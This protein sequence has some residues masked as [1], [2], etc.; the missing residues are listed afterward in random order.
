MTDST[1][2]FITRT[3]LAELSRQRDSLLAQYHE[4]QSRA[5]GDHG[6]VGLRVLYEGLKKIA[7]GH[8]RLH[9]ELPNIHALLRGTEV[10]HELVAFWRDRFN[11][12]LARGKARA[13]IVYL[14]GAF[15]GEWD[16]R[17]EVNQVWQNDRRQQY[18][19]LLQQVTASA[20]APPAPMNL[21]D[22][23]LNRLTEHHAEIAAKIEEAIQESVRSQ[24]DCYPRLTQI[25]DSPNHPADVRAE[26]K[27]FSGDDVLSD[28]FTDAL[29][30]VTRDPRDWSWPSS[31][32]AARALWTR[33]KWRLYPVLSL[34]DLAVLNA[35]SDFWT[36]TIASCYTNAGQRV[37]R[38]GRLQHLN[39]LGA[40][41]VITFNE[42]RMLKLEQE[43][44]C[45]SWY[46][47]TDPWTSQPV[48]REGEPVRGI[49]VSRATQQGELRDAAQMGYGYGEGTNAM[50]LQVHAEIQTLRAAFPN[51]PLHVVKLDIR[52]YFASVPHATLLRMLRGL[53]MTVDGMNFAECFLAI[54]YLIDEEASPARRGVPMEQPFSHWLCEWLLRLMEEFVYARARVRII[55]QIDDICLLAPSPDEAVAGW[56]AVREFVADCGLSI[57]E[58][59]CGA[60]TIGG[61]SVDE[62]PEQPPRWSMLELNSDGDW[63]IHERTFETLLLDAR[64]EVDARHAILARVRSYNEHLRF[65]VTALGLAMDLGD[66]HRQS[67]A[68]SLSQFENT[69]FGDNK[70]VFDG[71]RDSIRERYEDQFDAIPTSWMVWPITA[72]GLGLR[73][74]LIL[75]GQFQIAYENRCDVRKS[76]PAKRPDDWQHGDREWTEYYQDLLVKLEPAE[77]GESK[78]MKT[79]VKSFIRR[80]KT[81]SGGEQ[82]GLTQYWRW[83]LSIYGPEILEH[84]GTFEFLL[85][86]LVPLQ[87][88][89]E[90]LMQEDGAES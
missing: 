10:S 15:L 42:R 71:L 72:G 11:R 49:V 45:L 76:P 48:V 13:D 4:I 55:R 52:D 50:V 83:V 41:E 30:V 68:V 69:F 56:N 21:L 62:L 27:R 18:E 63:Q 66:V 90:K 59:K 47:E 65:L 64:R 67:A 33:N 2:Q 9:R 34:V 70:S 86:E 54:P 79:L 73:S 3:K 14:F 75:D 23:Q 37:N 28:Q 82:E 40:P 16:D 51:R 8:T 85:T 22:G 61:E 20:V 87:L 1:I 78:T 60:I 81:I 12:E 26:A 31:G 32:V 44:I 24:S 84:L 17:N 5:D 36:S 38:E 80:G 6:V 46:E 88:I 58:D 43:R 19:D 29:R 74:A 35:Y 77:C 53:G 7:V 39:D 89:Q 25:A 57:N